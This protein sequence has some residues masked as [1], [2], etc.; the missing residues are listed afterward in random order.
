[1]EKLIE[2]ICK[3]VSDTL[4]AHATVVV[5]SKGDDNLI[6][7]GG[8][9][10]W[11]FPQNEDGAYAGYYP[12]DSAQ[13]IAHLEALREKGGEFLLLPSTALWW[14]DHYAEFNQYLEQKYPVVFRQ[15]DVCVIFALSKSERQAQRLSKESEGPAVTG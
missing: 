8:R 14:L 3:V 7:L 6:D 15:N 13:V 11:H 10:G 5:V 1:Y 2:Q 12:H 4:P 9:Q